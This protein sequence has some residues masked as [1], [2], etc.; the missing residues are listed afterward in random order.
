MKKIKK[1]N[2]RMYFDQDVQDAIVLYNKEVNSLI[3]NKIYQEKIEYAFDKLCEN[4]INTFKF[5][6]FDAHFNDVKQEVLSFLVLNMHK[7]DA[8]K[9]FKAFSYF[10]VVAKNY[11]IFHN[12]N[13]YKQYKLRDNI[14]SRI[15]KSKSV[16]GID[17][18]TK[19]SDLLSE[20]I[21]YFENEIENIFKKD[22]DKLIA[23][24]ILNIIDNI[25]EIE[26]FNKKAIYI[27]LREMTNSP[28]A[29]LTRVINILKKKYV[30]LKVDFDQKGS[31]F[32]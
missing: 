13:N 18:L 12:N 11:L 32:K 15:V 6:Y 30:K 10:S 28:T 3:R 1:K 5:S 22:E 14:D 8:S 27:L 24:A 9:G 7:Y 4:I 31:V 19:N 2:K 21:V 16:E 23:Y 25:D 29:K 17:S 20:I 26:N